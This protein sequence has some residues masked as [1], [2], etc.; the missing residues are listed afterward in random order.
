MGW[1]VCRGGCRGGC[2]VLLLPVLGLLPPLPVRV[3][4]VQVGMVWEVVVWEEE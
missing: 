1:E 3:G 4:M 2:M